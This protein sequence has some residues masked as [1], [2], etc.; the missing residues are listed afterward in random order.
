ML[1][2]SRI[3][4]LMLHIHIGRRDSSDLIKKRA[5][6]CWHDSLVGGNLWIRSRLSG[7]F[8]D[9]R[10][11]SVEVERL[12]WTQKAGLDQCNIYSR[13]SLYLSQIEPVFLMTQ[14]PLRLQSAWFSGVCDGCV[15]HDFH[16]QMEMRRS[17]HFK[18]KIITIDENIHMSQS[19]CW[20]LDHVYADRRGWPA[21]GC[22]GK[23]YVV[24]ASIRWVAYVIRLIITWRFLS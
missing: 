11:D 2:N 8:K 18:T 10:D 16:S 24:C 23:Y 21:S 6:Q 17:S 12:Q 19:C 13:N 9:T 3:H 7:I 22:I 14:F 5:F 1:W 15:A 20:R 4:N